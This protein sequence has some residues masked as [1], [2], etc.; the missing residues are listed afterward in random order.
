VPALE[1]ST[2]RAWFGRLLKEELD[3]WI[4]LS[5]H[6]IGQLWQHYEVLLRWNERIGL[7]SIPP[8]REM[9]VRHY[10]ESLF[11]AAHLP[12]AS[13]TVSLLDFGS[14]GARQK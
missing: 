3:R 11:F 1:S 10:C 4:D 7:T 13:E 2:G 9:V 8:G 14:F 12:V 6:Q 5:E